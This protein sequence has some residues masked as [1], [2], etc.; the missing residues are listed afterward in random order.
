MLYTSEQG[1]EIILNEPIKI[2][3][4]T[5]RQST[6]TPTQVAFL[7]ES[8]STEINGQSFNLVH[9][10]GDLGYFLKKSDFDTTFE[11]N[12]QLYLS[13][14]ASQKLFFTE[15]SKGNVVSYKDGSLSVK[16][17]IDTRPLRISESIDGYITKANDDSKIKR[18]YTSGYLDDKELDQTSLASYLSSLGVSGYTINNMKKL[19]YTRYQGI[20]FLESMTLL[21]LFIMGSR[22]FFKEKNKMYLVWIIALVFLLVRIP[23]AHWPLHL[24]DE[25]LVS[26]TAYIN[27]IKAI[28]MKLFEFLSKD[29]SLM[30]FKEKLVILLQP[31]YYLIIGMMIMK[32]FK[33]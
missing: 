7:S 27:G 22:S 24:I 21:I 16:D 13:K 18:I 10:K 25:K 30:I 1:Y 8:Q 29:M 26:L 31:L 11:Q 3:D 17:T 20:I 14:S 15:N 28:P 33:K 9:V 4:T 2:S 32:G 12:N 6:M 5:I 19:S 23:Y